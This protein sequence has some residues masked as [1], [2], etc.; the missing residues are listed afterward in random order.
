M[1]LGS[2]LMQVVA[3]GTIVYANVLLPRAGNSQSLESFV[4]T[5][6]MVPSARIVAYYLVGSEIVSNSLWFDVVD[7]CKTVI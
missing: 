3:R 1:T 7:Q 2:F 5:Q 4:V 6:K